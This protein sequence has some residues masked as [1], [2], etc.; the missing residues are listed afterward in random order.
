[1]SLIM[2]SFFKTAGM[3][4]VYIFSMRYLNTNLAVFSEFKVNILK[5]NLS[6]YFCESWL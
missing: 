3:K 4:Y 5:N 6:S 2:S 1:M